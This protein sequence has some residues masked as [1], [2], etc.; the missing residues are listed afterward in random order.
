MLDPHRALFD[1]YSM[2]Y[3]RM[4]GPEKLPEDMQQLQRDRLPPWLDAI[5]R[6]ARLLDAGCG[7]GHLLMALHR[8]G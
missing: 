7:Q 3:E 5:P 6:N 8:V 1:K 4:A 2:H